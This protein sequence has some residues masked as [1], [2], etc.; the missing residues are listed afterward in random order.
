MD[1][2]MNLRLASLL[3]ALS[4]LSLMAQG[5]SDPTRPPPEILQPQTANPEAMPAGPRLQSV[6]LGEGHQGRELAVIDGEI[7]RRGDKFR[8]AVLE[9]VKAN[10]VVLRRGKQR[11][12]LR[13]Y[14]L[15]AGGQKTRSE[16]R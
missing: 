5:L 12:V 10:E 15:A 14:P 13:L 9:E 11:E 2:V 1:E 6:L 16:N 8:G 3:L 4:P 7:V